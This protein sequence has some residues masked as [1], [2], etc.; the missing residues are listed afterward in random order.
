M[1]EIQASKE[2]VDTAVGWFSAIMGAFVVAL[3]LLG[4]I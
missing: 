3:F 1:N 2:D 4:V